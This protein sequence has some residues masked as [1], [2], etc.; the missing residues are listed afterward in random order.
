MDPDRRKA[1]GVRKIGQYLPCDLKSLTRGPA[2][3][4][5]MAAGG[6]RKPLGE[7][8]L[9]CRA[10]SRER[11]DE[12]VRRQRL[13]RLCCCPLFEGMSRDELLFFCD[14]VREVSAPAGEKIIRQGT[15]GDSFY[16]LGNSWDARRTDPSWRP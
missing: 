12:A 5:Q 3:Q 8:L 2:L 1:Q 13:D 10:I 6:I 7:V 4:K 14:L 11:L 15:S 9:E 16:I